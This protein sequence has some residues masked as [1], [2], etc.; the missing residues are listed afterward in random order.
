MAKLV[1]IVPD[2]ASYYFKIAENFALGKGLTF[3]SIHQTNGVHPLW[4]LFITPLFWLEHLGITREII[5]RIIFFVQ[6]LFQISAGFLLYKSFQS[7]LNNNSA[8]IITALFL[9]LIIIRF[10]NGLETALFFF[11]IAL[12]IRQIVS[13]RQINHWFIAGI[14]A[15]SCILTRLDFIFIVPALFIV[16]ITDYK[17]KKLLNAYAVIYFVSG[18]ILLLSPYLI[19]NQLVFGN[20]VPISGVLK[21]GTP[22]SFQSVNL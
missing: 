13:I 4:L 11:L 19:Y 9:Y 20:M 5:F 16:A 17:N 2:D 1:N 7:V 14:I 18:V 22:G 12:L 6:T 21:S 3:D 15:G 10:T 8:F